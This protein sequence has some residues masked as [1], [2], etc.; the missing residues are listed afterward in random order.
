MIVLDGPD[1]QL[2]W[3]FD[4]VELFFTLDEFLDS[5]DQLP[6]IAA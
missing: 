3:S 2:L 1:G 4:E 6:G 5:F